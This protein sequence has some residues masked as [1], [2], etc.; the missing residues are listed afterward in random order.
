MSRSITAPVSRI[1]FALLLVAI[2]SSSSAQQA[3]S[4]EPNVQTAMRWWTPQQNVWTP[5]GWKD[6]LFRFQVVYNGHLLCTPAG[7]IDKPHILKYK[8]QDFQFS[9]YPSPDGSSCR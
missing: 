5:I 1:I 9:A 6:H 8:G 4:E 2:A 3:R 7:R